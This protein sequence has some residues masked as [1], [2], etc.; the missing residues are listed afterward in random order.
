M[1][2]NTL[3]LKSFRVLLLPIAILYGIIV[4]IRNRMFDKKWLASAQFNFPVICVGN[5]AVGGTGKSPM[6]EYLA[7]LLS[8]E[9]RIATLSRGY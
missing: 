1:N 9:F 4:I 2:F 3:F 5:L 7:N 8:P 6:V